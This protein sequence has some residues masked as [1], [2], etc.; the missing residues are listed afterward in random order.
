MLLQMFS[1]KIKV[2]AA[3]LRAKCVF[4]SECA[5]YSVCVACIFMFACFYVC[6]P[7]SPACLQVMAQ[8]NMCHWG[9]VSYRERWGLTQA[10][11]MGV[12]PTGSRSSDEE[13][14]DDSDVDDALLQALKEQEEVQLPN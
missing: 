2:T 12:L 11:G 13:D 5:V 7:A 9:G 8:M 10:L 3:K 4:L 14:S 1:K 6:E